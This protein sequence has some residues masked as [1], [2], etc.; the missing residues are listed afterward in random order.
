[1]KSFSK[2]LPHYL[3]L[4]GIFAAGTFGI[5]T[6]AYDRSLQMAVVVATAGAYV[7]WGVVHHFIHR[8]LYLA[9]I[10][11]YLVVAVLGVVLIFSLIFRV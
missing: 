2:H 10:V 8:D 11:E 3:S 5:Y 6:F 4:I 1:M 7:T 9:V